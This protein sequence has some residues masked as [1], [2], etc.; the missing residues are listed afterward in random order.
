MNYTKINEVTALAMTVIKKADL[1]DRNIWRAWVYQCV[2][3][4]GCSDNELKTCVLLPENGIAPLPDDCRQIVELGLYN[5]S[6][7]QLLHR[8]RPGKTRVY[9]DLRIVPSATGATQT[10]NNL[11]PV[12]V[13]NDEHS[14]HLGTNATLVTQILLRYFAYPFD[15]KGL[16]MIREEDAMACVYFIRFMESLRSNDNRSEIQQN[17]MMWKSEADRARARKKAESMT[18]EKAKTLMKDMMRMIPQFNL[19]QF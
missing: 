18:P 13:S 8:F 3:D 11:T 16:P 15:E 12:D 6:D 9:S 2:L 5:N 14:I 17:E 19:S 4:L 1:A 7:Q 10:I